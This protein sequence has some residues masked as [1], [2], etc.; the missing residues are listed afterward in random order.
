ME[1]IMNFFTWMLGLDSTVLNIWQMCARAVVVYIIA[2]IL[3]R[4]GKKRVLATPSPFDLILIL[5]LGS[6]IS[7]AITGAVPFFPTLAAAMT[8]VLLH[9]VFSY[10]TFYSTRVGA[11]IK[12]RPLVLIKDGKIQWDKMRQTQLTERD[13]LSALR[14]NAQVLDPGEVKMA[15]LE[16]NGEISVIRRKRAL[17]AVEIKVQDGV[18]T[19]KLEIKE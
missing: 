12:G 3:V 13:L 9:T 11:L 18:Q 4:L 17:D 5:I 2:L 14:R 15:I 8:L 16:R 7:R 10:I 19:V 1:S 6:V